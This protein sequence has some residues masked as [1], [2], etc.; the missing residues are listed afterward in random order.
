M[1]ARIISEET[2]TAVYTGRIW[3]KP[4]TMQMYMRLGS[5]WI[6]FAGAPNGVT[7]KSITVMIDNVDSTS[8]IVKGSLSIDD[9]LTQEANTCSFT[10]LDTDGLHKPS[11]GQEVFVFLKQNDSATPVLLFAGRITDCP[12][13]RV[14]RQVYEYDISC[15]DYTQDLQ[16][17]LVTETFASHT[18][19][20]IIK[21]IIAEYAPMIGT[22]YI[23]D[24]ATIDY[25]SFNYKFPDECITELAELMGY[26]WYVDYEKNLH[27][28]APTTNAAPYSLTD[29]VS[30][31]EYKDLSITVCK[32]DLKN[33]QVIRGGYEYSELFTEEQVADGT[34]TSFNLKYEPYTPITVYVNSGAGYVEHTLGIDNIDT[35]GKDFVV[36]VAEKNIKNLDHAALTAGHLM[37]VT[38]KYKIPVFSQ[39]ED[40]DSIEL[41][42]EYEGGDGIYEGELIV[43]DT[44]ETKAVARQRGKAELD[45][46]SNPLIEGSFTTI[47]HG[48]RSGQL[49]T[50]NIPSR[51]INSTYLIRD[52][53]INSHGNGLIEYNITFATRLK[54]LTSFLIGLYDNGR[55]T[56]ERTDEILDTYKLIDH[57][58]TINFVDDVTKT[59]LRMVSGHHYVWCNE[60]GTTP[61]KGQYNLCEYN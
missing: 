19:G 38:Y 2:P 17:N 56:F 32:T 8:M 34:Q 21:D 10:L 39:V 13:S 27:F 61:D 26:D 52:V 35:S 25:I 50:V 47:Q 59:A 44:I 42:Q 57:D 7:F 9:V 5:A 54:G 11:I 53:S 37:K 28:F 49:L 20:A 29:D 48:Y 24:G 58:I 33:K 1:D 6:P 43:D 18:A 22:Y 36:N 16:R 41:M 14:G 45:M 30:D 51:A 40:H 23:Q 4:S 46:Y 3:I 12:Q 31:G 55:K 15:I 60:A